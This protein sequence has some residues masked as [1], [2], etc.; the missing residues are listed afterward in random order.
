MSNHFKD[1]LVDELILEVMDELDRAD[2]W[3]PMNSPHEGYGVLMEEVDE[4]WTWIKTKQKN[5]DLA[6]MRREAIQVAAMAVRFAHDV[7]D[8]QRGRK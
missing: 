4:L 2:V 7:C 5:R 8:E 1:Q 3:P 6:A